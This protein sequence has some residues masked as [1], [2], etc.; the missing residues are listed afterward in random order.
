MKNN[1]VTDST[2]RSLKKRASK[3]DFNSL[4]QLHEYYLK[5]EFVPQS[6]ETANEYL[7]KALSIFRNQKLKVTQLVIENFRS[8]YEENLKLPEGNLAVII[9]NNGAGKTTVL[10]AIAC[11]ISWLHNRIVKQGGTGRGIDDLDITLGQDIDY[12]SV[13]AKFSF[14]KNL[15]ANMRVVGTK[16][17]SDANQKSHIKEITTIGKMYKKAN[18]LDKLFNM[19]ILAYYTVERS[20]DINSKDVGNFDE[21]PLTTEADKFDGYYNSLNGKADF[22]YFFRWFKRLDD[23]DKHRAINN[24][25]HVSHE[26]VFIDRLKVLAVKDAQA[27]AL[28]KSIMSETNNSI[29]TLS[30][31]SSIE[32]IKHILN[33]V[34]GYFMEGYGNIAIQMEPYLGI[35]IEKNGQKLNVLQLSQGEKSFL[36]LVLDITR[37]LILLNPSLENPLDGHGVILIDEVDLHLHPSWQRK[38]IKGLPALFKNCQFIVTT[39]SPQIFGEVK[40][41][42]I[43]ILSE[44]EDEGVKF[45]SPS[46]A[47]GLTSNDILNQYMS[48]NNLHEQLGRSAAVEEKLKEIYKLISNDLFSEAT[49]K[50]TALECELN[51]EIPELVSAR[52]DIDLANWDD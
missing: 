27:K 32:K 17:G 35:T 12:S 37:R 42:Q 9:G 31:A 7:E 18:A 41:S 11:N 19:P 3:G 14:N 51:G 47:Y 8:I 29:E 22:K 52:I 49:E 28:L 36:A 40:H 24:S 26:K 2:I 38:I 34:V 15:H 30:N 21:V 1:R 43:V 46:Q 20:L 39:H 33:T 13:I 4:F 16:D 48:N 10:D 6:I 44:I 45:S 23:I 25:S 5:G 50:I